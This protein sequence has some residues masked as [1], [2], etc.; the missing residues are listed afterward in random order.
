MSTAGYTGVISISTDDSTYNAINGIKSID[1]PFSADE[2]DTTAIG[3][4]QWRNSIQGL[5]SMDISMDG[6]YLPSDTAQTA[7][8]SAF[9]SGADFSVGDI[10]VNATGIVASGGTPALGVRVEVEDLCSEYPG[11]RRVQDEGYGRQGGNGAHVAFGLVAVEDTAE[12]E[13][14]GRQGGADPRREGI[15]KGR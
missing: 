1:T 2:L 11:D 4:S 5:K 7:I 6:D 10:R 9:T 15:A 14:R 8:R 12:A 3:G 13:K